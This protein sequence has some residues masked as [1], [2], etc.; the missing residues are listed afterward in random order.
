MMLG[1]ADTMLPLVKR[2]RLLRQSLSKFAGAE[3]HQ[4]LEAWRLSRDPVDFCD[5][6]LFLQCEHIVE[7]THGSAIHDMTDI[8]ERKKGRHLGWQDDYNGVF[9]ENDNELNGGDSS[10]W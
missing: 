7:A 6:E 10:E 8:T 3:N 1:L 9:N 4:N 5:R 2:Q